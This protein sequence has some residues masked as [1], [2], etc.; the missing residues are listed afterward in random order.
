MKREKLLIYAHYYTPDVASTGQLITELAEGLTKYYDITVICVVPSY[1]GKIDSYYSSQTV[2]KE[3]V[4]EVN[5]IR[6]RVPEYSKENKKSR[7]MNILTYFIRAIIATLNLPSQ[8]YIMSI[9]QPP[10]LGGVLGVIGKVLKRGQLIYTIQDFNPEQTSAVNYSKNK[11][12]LKLALKA[13]TFSCRRSDHIIVVGRDMQDT[14]NRRFNGKKGVSSTFINNWTDE[15]AIYPLSDTHP[16]VEAFK[17]KYALEGKFVVQ[18]SGN[19]GL[20]YDLENIFD[21]I[22]R[23]KDRTDIIFAFIG[24]GSVKNKLIALKEDM[25]LTNVVFIPYQDK[26]DLNY[27][28]NAG[29]LHWVVNAKGIKGIS[30]PSKLYGVM[31]AGKPVI[32]VLEEGS[33]A[34]LLIEESGCGMVADPG[35]YQ[36]IERTLNRLLDESADLK[37]RGILG[38]KHLE[39]YLSKEESL[40]KYAQTISSLKQTAVA[41]E[42]G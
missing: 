19:L 41:S 4:N 1:T 29:D 9:S 37:Q 13:D 10:I 38:R 15:K 21:V 40:E 2:F 7:L 28:L 11:V 3:V 12:L 25:N 31:A 16:R 6:V 26:K 23:F 14:L 27:S 18:Y 20:Y 30:V 42:R 35:N 39:N 34:R 5:V 17:E 36:Q 32:G 8:D 33:E 24:E 22:S